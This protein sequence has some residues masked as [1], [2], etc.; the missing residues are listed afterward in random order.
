MHEARLNVRADEDAEPDEIDAEFFGGGR[1]H[2][3]NDEGYF[4]KIE[5]KRDQENEGVGK[6]Q[7]TDRTSRQ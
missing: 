1:Q 2:R 7:E 5:E 4:E 6:D 3:N